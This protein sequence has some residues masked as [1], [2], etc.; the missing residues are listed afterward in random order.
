MERTKLVGTMGPASESKEVLRELILSGLNV[1]RMNFS[2]G[3]HEEHFKRLSRVR[4]LNEELG[5]T[6]AIMLDTKGPE[7]R[8]HE[9][10]NGAVVIEAGSEF[11]I[12][13]EQVLGTEKKFSINYPG[14]FDDV[15]VGTRILIDDGY[16][17]T[18]VIK[19][20]DDT[21]TLT[22]K[23]FNTHRIKNRR[24]V[25]VPN[26][27]INIPFL[28]QKDKDDIIF[29]AQH[30]VDYIAASFVQNKE[31]ILDIKKL[32]KEHNAEEIQV[33]AK[34]ENQEGI[35]NIDEI[36]EAADGIMVARGD[37]GVEILPEELPHLQK[38]LVEKT[39]RAGKYIIVATQMLESMQNNPVPTRAEV[40]DVANAVYDGADSVMLSGEMAAG[41]YPIESV[42]M[43]KRIVTATEKYVDYED[44]LFPTYSQD[45]DLDRV[46]FMA[47]TA[48]SLYGV[49]A[50]V[51]DTLA[52]TKQII[53]Y[54]PEAIV[55]PHLNFDDARKAYALFNSYPVVGT[56]ANID[57]SKAELEKGD[58]YL[59]VTADNIKV[60]TF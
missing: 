19:K 27:K 7:M 34:I 5:K 41:K 44:F 59:V 46:A 43:M 17:Q 60:E 52:L 4:E 53:K 54:R 42:K 58:K 37:L 49:K 38:E 40:S 56:L 47:K 25:N 11:E 45:E 20:D 50:I 36:L 35:D 24:G 32:L 9:F 6:V 21:R 51:T 26:T 30:K 57:L 10:E 12:V 31:N 13:F 16:L 29:G 18:E 48:A 3:D 8:T 55:L 1:V 28:S 23:A 14:L 22:C 33:V 2:H 39:R 15:N